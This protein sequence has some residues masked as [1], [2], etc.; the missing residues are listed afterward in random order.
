[1]KFL[2]LFENTMTLDYTAIA[3]YAYGAMDWSDDEYIYMY[4]QETG[5]SH[6]ADDESGWDFDT[7]DPDFLKW[8]H[9]HI[10]EQADEVYRIISNQ[11]HGGKIEVY[12][13][14][15]A[16]RD[17]TPSDRH[18][19]IYWSWDFKAAE[20]HWGSFDSTHIKWV[21]EATLNSTDIDW[22]PTIAMNCLSQ[23]K[24]EKEIRVKPG[25]HIE[26]TEYYEDFKGRKK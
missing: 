12:R 6:E 23:F 3:V 24:D 26:I 9:Q 7:K 25:T 10:E 11:I 19:G 4:R 21:M 14:I 8:F 5:R 18:P 17:W 1:M 13:V 22:I 16:P 15:T 2:R 20:A